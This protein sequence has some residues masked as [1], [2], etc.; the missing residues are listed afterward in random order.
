MVLSRA[1]APTP[2][3]RG[4]REKNSLINTAA[5][6]GL[7]VAGLLAIDTGLMRAALP[8]YYYVRMGFPLQ[9]LRIDRFGDILSGYFVQK[10]AKHL[11][12]V[13]RIGDP[14]AEH[15]RTPHN[16]FKDLYFELAGMVIVEE[17]LPWM[18]ELKLEGGD[19]L[20]SYRALADAMEVAA[21]QFKG[22][23]W[24]EGGREFLVDT[25][26]CMRQWLS[27]VQRFA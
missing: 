6:I 17:L 27:I 21:P 2:P 12:H 24:D 11:G 14:V 5:D 20:T 19:Y 9:G 22:F 7:A 4:K 3:L 25:A 8:A 16:L 13:V 15:K 10:C 23:I 1:E 18:I 26:H